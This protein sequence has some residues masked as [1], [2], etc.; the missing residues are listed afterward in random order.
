MNAVYDYEVYRC[1]RKIS[2]R[3]TCSGQ[4]AYKTNVL[5]EAVE[6]QVK[7]FLSRIQSIPQERLMQLAS[8][9]NEETYKI[10]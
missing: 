4:T 9:R 10:A 8:A 6:T 5:N 2:S 7:L 1:Y 3:K